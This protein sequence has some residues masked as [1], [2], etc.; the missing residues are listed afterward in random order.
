MQFRLSPGQNYLMILS[1]S[2]RSLPSSVADSA[3]GDGRV[4]SDEIKAP[5]LIHYGRSGLDCILFQW[6]LVQGE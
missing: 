5:V 2:C 3:S 4:S 6:S 1:V